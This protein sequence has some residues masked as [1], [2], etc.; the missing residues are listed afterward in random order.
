LDAAKK[1]ADLFDV[2]VPAISKHLNNIFASG[3]LQKE[4]TVSILETVQNEGKLEVARKVEFIITCSVL[5]GV[6]DFL[7]DNGTRNRKINYFSS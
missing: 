7:Y 1:I 3:E 2:N 6:L 5:G 4:G